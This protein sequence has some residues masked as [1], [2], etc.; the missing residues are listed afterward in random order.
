M[1]RK[2]IVKLSKMYIP[3]VIMLLVIGCAVTHISR[4]GIQSDGSI[5]LPNNWSLTPVGNQIPVGD[6]PLAMAV[7]PDDAYLLVTNNGY[8]DQYVSVIDVKQR[9]EISSIP[10]EE[11]W[12]GLIFNRKG[13]RIYVSGGGADEIEIHSFNKGKTQHIKTLKVKTDDDKKPYFVSGLALSDDDRMLLACALLQ[14]KLIVF[15]LEGN[16]SPKYIYVGAYPY[17]VVI[18]KEEKGNFAYVSNWGGS[19]ISVVD[20]EKEDEVAKIAVGDHPNAMALSPDGKKLFITSAN[21]NEL[22]IVDTMAKKA[23]QILNLS[24]YPGASRSG[25]TPNDITISKDGKNVYLVSADNNCVNVVD[26]SGN[27]ARGTGSI[28]TGWYPTAVKLTSDDKT[29]F[30]ANGKGL[31]SK[32]N[33]KGPQPTDTEE[34]M[35]YIGRLFLGTVSV[36]KV[37]DQAQLAE[38]TRQVVRNNSFGDIIKKLQ[39]GDAT[40]TPRA[41]PR[42]LGEPSL[43][44]YVFY[45]IKENRTYD[46]VFGDL[47]QG[48]GDPN[49][50]LFGRDITPNHHALAETFVLFDNFYVDAEVSQDGHSW[51]TGA[52][53]TD[54][55]EKLWPTN[56]SGRNFPIPNYLSVS[57]PSNRFSVGCGGK[58]R[59]K[60]S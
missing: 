30:V 28:P 15:D 20:L 3:I 43:I 60:L 46:Q 2:K 12:L 19:S 23:I 17:T 21:S 45:I 26:V 7:T 27:R 32:S 41:I 40:I 11:S 51:S 34:S 48:A 42:R 13:N 8:T 56:Y 36:L 37:P 50:T 18:N 55:L 47:T 29:L 4:P 10:M 9:K 16:N 44:K 52:Y 39:K 33:V 54:F 59:C 5:L 58:C 38:Y 24:P 53:A 31:S 14:R 49:L 22:T 57:Y 25:S 6:L 1:F 35:E